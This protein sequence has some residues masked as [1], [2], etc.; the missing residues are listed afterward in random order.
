MLRVSPRTIHN[1]ETARVR[2]PYA[3]YKLMRILRGGKHLGPQ[4][5]DFHIVGDRLITPEGHEFPAGDLAWWSL[6]V[7][8]AEMFRTLIRERRQVQQPSIDGSLQGGR[9]AAL[10]AQPLADVAKSLLGQVRSA[11]LAVRPL[12]GQQNGSE[13]RRTVASNASDSEGMASAASCGHVGQQ[14]PSLTSKP[15]G[16]WGGLSLT[17][18]N[19]PKNAAPRAKRGR[20]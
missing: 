17:P 2:I 5:R 8:Q 12:Q 20:A 18:Q 16:G 3:A 15:S 9:Q 14:A 1:W 11:P 19:R 13:G 6:L 4:W 10:E 7:R